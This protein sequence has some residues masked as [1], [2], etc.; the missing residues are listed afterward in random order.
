[1]SALGWSLTSPS[2][3]LSLDANEVA[4]GVGPGAG[5]ELM[6]LSVG[7]C[8]FLALCLNCLLAASVL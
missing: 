1:M 7:R 6:L 3:N 4:Q 5:R 8:I 2:A